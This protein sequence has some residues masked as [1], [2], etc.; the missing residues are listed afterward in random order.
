MPQYVRQ[1]KQWRPCSV[2][3]NNPAM[4][5][6][7]P[8]IKILAF[9]QMQLAAEYAHSCALHTIST[10]QCNQFSDQ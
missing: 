4:Q 9:A 3:A 1:S 2:V 10:E 7:I 6:C 8:K 5:Y